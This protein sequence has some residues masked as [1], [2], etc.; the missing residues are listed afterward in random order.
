M[1]IEIEALDTFIFQDGKPFDKSGDNWG[2]S[3]VLPTPSTLYG[4][5]RATYFANHI[6]VL[7]KANEDDDPTKDL[8][9]NFIG[10]KYQEKLIFVMPKD[11]IESKGEVKTLD[12]EKNLLTNS[13]LKHTLSSKEEVESIDKGYLKNHN[14]ERYLSNKT[15]GSFE[16]ED[17]LMIRENKIGIGLNRKTKITGE[18]LL[19]RVEML[20]YKELKIV[21]DF[22]GLDLEE[23]GFMKFGGEAKGAKYQQLDSLEI[24]QIDNISSNIFKL[25]LLTPAIFDNGWYPSW[26]NE[27][28]NNFIGEFNGFKIKLVACAMGKHQSIG[29]FDIKK[30]EPKKMMKAVP[31]GSIYYFEILE[32]DR[33]KV[34]EAFK[35]SLISDYKQ[36]EGYGLVMI[37]DVK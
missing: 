18:G 21:V 34:V 29:G 37:G 31:M 19:Y 8:K 11:C 28:N 26:I 4:A 2:N 7:S 23:S 10:L 22:N 13:P 24:P 14:L 32:G 15:I 35:L 9:I 20:R 1:T 27:D 12:L 25:Y 3:L 17:S 36:E 30:R 6:D 5:L 33:D 16:V